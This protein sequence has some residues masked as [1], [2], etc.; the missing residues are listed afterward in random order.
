MQM[1][2]LDP[3]CEQSKLRHNTVRIWG[4]G[5]RLLSVDEES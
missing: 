5:G 4:G 3:G 1:S 2:V